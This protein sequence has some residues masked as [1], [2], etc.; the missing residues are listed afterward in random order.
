MAIY[1]KINTNFWSDPF[2]CDLPPEKKL[3]FL[4][5]ITNERTKQCGIYD[6]SKR[7]ISFDLSIDNKTVTENIQFFTEHGK[8][9]FSERT[10]E[11]A[12]RNWERYN[13]STSPKVVTCVQS[14]LKLVKNRVLIDYIYGIYTVS[15][16]TPAQEETPTETQEPAQEETPTQKE[17]TE[18]VISD[19]LKI[20]PPPEKIDFIKFQKFFNDNRK[21]F[22]EVKKMTDA[23]KKR[24]KSLE[25]QY[26]KACLMHC[27]EKARDS[28]FLQGINSKNWIAS[29][30]WI[31]TPANFIKILEDNYANRGQQQGKTNAEIFN[32]AMQSDTAKNFRFGT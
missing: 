25:S 32:D 26:G 5:L 30:D 23:R 22:A 16:E 21:N 8:I 1:R 24:L 15:Q 3:F 13:G 10:N 29:F 7:Q 2:I 31:F 12:I 14:E 28:D 20:D 27:V 11:V 9:M 4:Y 18:G 19:Q 6:I 17:F